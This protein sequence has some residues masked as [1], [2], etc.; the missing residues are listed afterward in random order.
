MD[1]K[2]VITVSSIVAL[3]TAL[4]TLLVAFGL[5]ITPDQREALI[6]LVAVAAPFIIAAFVHPRVTPLANPKVSVL[7]PL[8]PDDPPALEDTPTLEG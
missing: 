8:T 4:L 2:P 1:E 3:V 5:P 7:V 6:G